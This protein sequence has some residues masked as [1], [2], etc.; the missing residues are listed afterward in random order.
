MSL[1]AGNIVASGTLVLSG[2]TPVS[3]PDEAI[4]L[5]S[6]SCAILDVEGGAIRFWVHGDDPSA[7][8][9][10]P[11]LENDSR[12]IIGGGNVRQLRMVAQDAVGGAVVTWS[13]GT[14]AV[15]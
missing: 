15:L 3:L 13:V 8:I 2:T 6:V 14:G 7:L 5:A 9:G 10:H 11:V 1:Y 4:N 12:S